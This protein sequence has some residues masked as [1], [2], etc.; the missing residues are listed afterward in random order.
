MNDVPVRKM[1]SGKME[2]KMKHEM[3]LHV[4]KSLIGSVH[5]SDLVACTVL[6]VA[7]KTITTYS[8]HSWMQNYHWLLHC[9][10]F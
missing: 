2:W 5:K 3:P 10:K 7:S 4:E 6:H 8:I 9:Y 1:E